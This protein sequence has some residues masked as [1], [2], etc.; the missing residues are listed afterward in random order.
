MT[1]GVTE[2]VTTSTT[3]TRACEVGTTNALTLAI[4]RSSVCSGGS[5]AAVRTSTGGAN[6]TATLR[7]VSAY[8]Q[9]GGFALGVVATAAGG[10]TA[11][12]DARNV[13]ANGPGFDVQAQSAAGDGGG[14]ASV[15]LENSNYQTEREV[16][17]TGTPD[18]VTDPGSGTNQTAQARFLPFITFQ[19]AF[20]S[21]TINAGGNH[22]LLGNFDLGG[23][24]RI[25]GSAPDIGADEADGTVPETTITDGPSGTTSD[26]TPTFTFTSS[27]PASFT[28]RI[29]GGTWEICSGPDNTHTTAALADGQ[30]TFEVAA[31]DFYNIDP[32]PASRTFTV[33]TSGGGGSGGGG[34]GGAT[35]DNDPPET[36]ITRGPPDET[37]RERAK[38]RFTSDE[39]ASTF[40]CRLDRGAYA[41]C[42]SPRRYRNLDDGRHRFRVRAIDAAG[43]ADPSAARDRWVI[44]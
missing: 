34:G 38:F 35:P 41:A 14:I 17:V 10:G 25:E 7:N 37:S 23:G 44:G 1:D 31:S 16:D 22:S 4:L 8:A 6:V 13:V 9:D 27:E 18:S 33:S 19:Q 29:D 36:T 40:E 42:T 30:H 5:V 24:P 32:T 11:T 3:G 28:C 39:A 15:Q 12:I 21:P 2:R 43:N 20:D 26:N